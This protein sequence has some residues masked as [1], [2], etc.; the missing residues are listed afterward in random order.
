MREIW[1]YSPYLFLHCVFRIVASPT[2]PGEKKMIKKGVSIPI[3]FLFKVPNYT[4]KNDLEHVRGPPNSAYAFWT[5]QTYRHIYIT[6]NLDW[7]P[8]CGACFARPIILWSYIESVQGGYRNLDGG[9][10]NHRWIYR[11]GHFGFLMWFPP[12]PGSHHRTDIPPYVKI[13]ELPMLPW[14]FNNVLIQWFLFTFVEYIIIG[15]KFGKI[16]S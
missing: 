15:K 3:D 16:V 6:R 5:R 7:T 10:L 9:V 11:G 4:P 12:P 8:Q 2:H 14:L 13:L 1:V